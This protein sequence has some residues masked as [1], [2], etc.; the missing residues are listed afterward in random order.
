MIQDELNIL[1]N[2]LK[3]SNLYLEKHDRYLKIT[4]TME[5]L[6]KEL[7]IKEDRWLE[8]LEIEEKLKNE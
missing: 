6:N 5:H 8:I 7:K 4:K 3:E 2:E 1:T